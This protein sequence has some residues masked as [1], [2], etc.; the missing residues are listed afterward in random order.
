MDLALQLE[1]YDLVRRLTPVPGREADIPFLAVLDTN[2][3]AVMDASPDHCLCHPIV[4]R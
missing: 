3:M 1:R 2:K 4:L